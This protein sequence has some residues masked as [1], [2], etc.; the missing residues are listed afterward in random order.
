MEYKTKEAIL[1]RGREAIGVSI[2]DMDK[3]YRLQTGK[4]AVGNVVQEAWFGCKVNNESKPDF[5]EAG[6]E[7]KV[8]PYIKTTKGIRAKERLVANII[9]YM[10]E[11]KKT[12]KT[13]S[14]WKKCNTILLMSYEHKPD[15]DKSDFTI[16]EAVLFN[17]SEEDLLIIEQDWITIVNKIRNGQAHE[18]SEGDTLYLG[19]CTKGATSA[20]VRQQPFSSIP[21]KQRAFSLKQSYMTYV[22]NTFIFG[23]NVYEHIIKNPELLRE[24]RFED[25][26][27]DTLSFYLGRTQL[28]LLKEFSLEASNKTKNVNEI[29][30]ARML[31]IKG[32]ITAT[33]EFQ[34]ANIIPKTIRIQKNG[35]IKESMSF[36]NFKFVEIIQE[37]WEESTLKNYIEPTKFLF[38]I[39][40]ECEDGE[41]VFERIKFWNIP[42]E[43]LE[44][45]RKVWERT[46]QIIKEGVILTKVGNVTKNNLPKSTENRVSHVRPHGRDSSDTYLLPDGRK[47]T[48]QCFW[49]NRKYIESIIL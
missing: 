1:A 19:A 47:M 46:V 32:R 21:A 44:E 4:G 10:E 38:V 35:L 23:E 9:N 3:T 24:K 15:V 25:Y 40:K 41:Y 14:F 6:V 7:L 2:G 12:F 22:L 49:F 39:F 48:K 26:V 5:E 29:I 20:S 42:S 13:S 31:G 45:V 18:L 16:D 33:D 43:D 28:S 8:T 11:Y 36:P 37:T 17:F 27:I 30:L 34:K